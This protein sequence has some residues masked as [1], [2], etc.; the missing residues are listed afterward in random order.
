MSLKVAGLPKAAVPVV[1]TTDRA[2]AWPV[3]YSDRICGCVIVPRGGKSL[4]EQHCTEEARVPVIKHLDGNCHV[5][6][7]A[8]ADLLKALPIA[9]ECQNPSLWRM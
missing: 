5:Y 6:V 1:N 7:E 9:L 2:A 3:D 4:I 8:Q